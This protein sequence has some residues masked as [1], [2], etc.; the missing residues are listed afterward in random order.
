MEKESNLIKVR[1]IFR[2][3]GIFLCVGSVWALIHKIYFSNN[4]GLDELVF[5]IISTLSFVSV[6]LP[7][8]I[9][10]RVPEYISK[11]L[12]EEFIN[13]FNN[14]EKL[15][16]EFNAKSV[17]FAIVFLSMVLYSIYISL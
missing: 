8:C 3:L 4:S 14:A 7:S 5:Y 9:L 2:I 6:I 17:G 12:D 1:L 13:D 10:G 15:F 16:T 11:H